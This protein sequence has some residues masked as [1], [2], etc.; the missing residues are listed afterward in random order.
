MWTCG[1]HFS[2]II[3]EEKT[4]EHHLVTQGIYSWVMQSWSSQYRFI[5]K[6]QLRIF[7]FSFFF[8]IKIRGDNDKIFLIVITMNIFL[9]LSWMNL[10]FLI[11]IIVVV[12]SESR[13]PAYVYS[14]PLCSSWMHSPRQFRSALFILR[15]SFSVLLF[16]FPSFFSYSFFYF[17]SYFCLSFCLTFF[18]TFFLLFF[19]FLCVSL[20]S[21][22]PYTQRSSPPCLLWL[23]LLEHR[24]PNIIM[25]PAVLCRLFPRFMVVF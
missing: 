18:L 17:F 15:R 4:R 7:F 10:L 24:N 13:Q 25:Q 9:S 21:F 14:V 6:F 8:I 11:T 16:F 23:V 1:P 12:C 3:M 19:Y 20:P 2:H 5:T 22:F